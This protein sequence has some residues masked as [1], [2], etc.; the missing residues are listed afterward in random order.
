MVPAT[1]L[2][3]TPAQ[4]PIETSSPSAIAAPTDRVLLI[5][6]FDGETPLVHAVDP[7]TGDEL[8]TVSVPGWEKFKTIQL[9]GGQIFYE[10]DIGVRR[11]SPG[12]EA[13]DLVFVE[14]RSF[15]P[16]RD[17][18]WIAWGGCRPDPGLPA[19]HNRIEVSR[20]DGSER[21]MVFDEEHDEPIEARPFEWSEDGRYL[22]LYHYNPIAAASYPFDIRRVDLETGGVT[23]LLGQGDLSDLQLSPDDS[24]VAYSRLGP[25]PRTLSLLDLTTGRETEVTLDA[26]HRQAGGIVWAPD[27]SALAITEGIGVMAREATAVV[28]VDLQDMRLR[29]LLPDDPRQLRTL[30]WLDENWI[31]LGSGT[32][33][34]GGVWRLDATTGELT[35]I[36]PGVLLGAIE[37]ASLP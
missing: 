14:G 29:T 32:G 28:R 24:M 17:G 16:S 4:P 15:L 34:N 18:S 6:T 5:A 26:D 22:Y 10:T 2:P 7:D 8:T 19:C 3:E 36:H 35:H 33:N 30:L 1:R 37:A 31:I 23:P 13:D 21:R 25:E 27:S 12:G 11:T 9:A 20:A